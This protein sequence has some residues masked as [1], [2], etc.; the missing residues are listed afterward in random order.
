M[1][2]K[3]ERKIAEKRR[4]AEEGET[5]TV[6]PRKQSIAHPSPPPAR[7]QEWE[8]APDASRSDYHAGRPDEGLGNQ[9]DLPSVW[10]NEPEDRMKH[11]CDAT[12]GDALKDNSATRASEKLLPSGAVRER[13]A[14]FSPASRTGPSGGSSKSSV[15]SNGLAVDVDEDSHP[16]SAAGGERVSGAA[17]K[18]FAEE[19]GTAGGAVVTS[20]AAP[21]AAD[22][23]QAAAASTSQEGAQEVAR[24]ADEARSP[25]PVSSLKMTEAESLRHRVLTL[26][27][28]SRKL[29]RRLAQT[30][31]ELCVCKATL[32]KHGISTIT[33][34][35]RREEQPSMFQTLWSDF[36]KSIAS[37][38]GLTEVTTAAA[39]Q[40]GRRRTREDQGGGRPSVDVDGEDEPPRDHG[41]AGA[42]AA[43]GPARSSPSGGARNIF[44]S[45]GA[46][47]RDR[48]VGPRNTKSS[49]GASTASSPTTSPKGGPKSSP[50][51]NK[52]PPAGQDVGEGSSSSSAAASGSCSE[53]DESYNGQTSST[54][55]RVWSSSQTTRFLKVSSP[56]F[57]M[58]EEERNRWIYDRTRW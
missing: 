5:W 19:R 14:N 21:G 23:L 47:L 51:P 45:A 27:D 25:E 44:A 11:S 31:E 4:L 58:L 35:A 7:Y 15:N 32:D 33:G 37:A 48:F 49:N 52:S 42:R 6:E 50:A 10:E 39:T 16:S 41:S 30:T 55:G 54:S 57:A 17:A 12:A 8:N 26:E 2:P 38:F 13:A 53:D 18:K 28:C 40:G 9:S 20:I 24:S 3:L 1:D 22:L 29:A 36:S 56:E 34:D 46:S 43:R